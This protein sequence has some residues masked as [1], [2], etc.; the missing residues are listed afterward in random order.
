M[1]TAWLTSDVLG[2]ATNVAGDR[3]GQ[4]AGLEVFQCL[5]DNGAA[6]AEGLTK[7][8]LRR[9]SIAGLDAPA[10]NHRFDLFGHLFVQ[11]ATTDGLV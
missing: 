11:A 7:L 8:A 3:L 4:T 2:V 1:P 9:E 5:A 6:D 10:A